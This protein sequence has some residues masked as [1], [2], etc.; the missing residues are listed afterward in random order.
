MLLETV[1]IILSRHRSSNAEDISARGA[2]LEPVLN[3]N[4]EIRRYMRSRRTVADV[5]PETGQP[6]PLPPTGAGEATPGP[7]GEGG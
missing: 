1:V 4:E 2:L 7:K 3:Q 6:D 5:D